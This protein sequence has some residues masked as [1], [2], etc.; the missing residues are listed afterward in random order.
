[1]SS[2]SFDIPL[3]VPPKDGEEPANLTALEQ[4]AVAAG[5]GHSTPLRF[6]P[7]PW[8]ELEGNSRPSYDVHFIQTFNPDMVEHLLHRLMAAERAL[9]ENGI[10]PLSPEAFRLQMVREHHAER[11]RREN[12]SKA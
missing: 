11:E 7:K 5:H 4:I 1:M 10:T 12:E 3:A 6:G 2:T 8:Y 9:Q